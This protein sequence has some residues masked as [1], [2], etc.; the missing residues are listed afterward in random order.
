MI[1]TKNMRKRNNFI[2]INCSLNFSIILIKKKQDKPKTYKGLRTQIKQKSK[3]ERKIRM[4]V[5]NPSPKQT[6]FIIKVSIKERI[7]VFS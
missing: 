7:F 6:S 2:A 1:L 5:F 4:Y 3:K